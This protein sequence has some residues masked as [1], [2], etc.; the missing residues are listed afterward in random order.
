L[1]RSEAASLCFSDI[2]VFR[3]EK[4]A[5]PGVVLG[6]EVAGIVS[7]IG[8]DVA[9][10]ALGERVA[11]CPIIACGACYFCIRGKRNRC[12]DRRTL[13]YEADGGLAE[14]VLAPRELVSL[15]HV[16]KVPQGLPW[17]LACQMEPFACSLYSLETCRI[18]P[19]TSLAI[20]GA[21]PMGL[22]HLLIA[23]AM[24]CSTIVVSDPVESRLAVAAELGAST[25]VN[26]QRDVLKDSVLKMTDG[27]GADAAIVTVGNTTA[28]KDGLEVVRKQ[29][30]VNIFG[31]CPPGSTLALDPNLV[32]Y[33][34]LWVTGTQNSNPEHYQ[35]A[36]TLLTSIPHAQRLI[37]HRFSIDE[38]P[39]AFELRSQMEGLKAV[40]D[41]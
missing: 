23:K 6:H 13:G 3:G 36:L 30:I 5:T 7:A 26:P 16:L 15:G 4:K 25:V 32:H 12:L 24:G 22:T 9:G 11:I 28:I 38:A 20:I 39:G 33:N 10:I 41:F 19:G 8:P 40:V 34:E 35:R 21:G 18:G 17:D 27:L 31:G 1:V 37:T 29:G 14:Y 2:R